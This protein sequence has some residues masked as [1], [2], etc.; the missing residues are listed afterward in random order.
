M[1]LDI[2]SI[3]LSV[4]L[5]VMILLLEKKVLKRFSDI[6]ND[7]RDRFNSIEKRPAASTQT[8]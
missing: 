1:V 5:L 2:I 8:R 3:C 6:E 4:G 7:Q